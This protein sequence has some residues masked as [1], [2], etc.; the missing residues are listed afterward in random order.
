MPAQERSAALLIPGRAAI[1]TAYGVV[2][3]RHL[4][5]DTDSLP[6]EAGGVAHGQVNSP[7]AEGSHPEIAHS[8]LISSGGGSTRRCP[9]SRK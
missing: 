5:W 7:P 9:T 2:E 1:T 4:C 3:L 6:L 8:G